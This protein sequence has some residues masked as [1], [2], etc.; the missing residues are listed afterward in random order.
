MQQIDQVREKLLFM[1]SSLESE[2][3]DISGML[4]FIHT[5]LRKDPENVTLLSDEEKAL[6][7]RGLKYQ[8]RT[9]LAVAVTKKR[10]PKKAMTMDDIL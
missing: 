8:T 2:N 9:E 1:E 7:I 3:P 10:K 6:V 4:R 5:A